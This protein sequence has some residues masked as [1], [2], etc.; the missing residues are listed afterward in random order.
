MLRETAWPELVMEL[1]LALVAS[2]ACSEGLTQ[3]R[4]RTGCWVRFIGLWV[5]CLLLLACSV[6]ALANALRC[7]RQG[8]EYRPSYEAG[9]EMR[10]WRLGENPVTKL[11]AHGVSKFCRTINL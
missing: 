7:I 2:L 4:Y 10:A 3:Q 8:S 11:L 9:Q 5:C 1:G 6:T